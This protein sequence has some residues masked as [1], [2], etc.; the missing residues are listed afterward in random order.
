M[1]ND[2]LRVISS[3]NITARPSE[4]FIDLSNELYML[5]NMFYSRAN[6]RKLFSY[7][8]SRIV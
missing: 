5:L 8:A 7:T 1:I 4:P 3:L 2:G 6:T